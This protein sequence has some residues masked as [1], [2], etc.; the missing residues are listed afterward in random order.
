VRRTEI[1]PFFNLHR[2]T[3]KFITAISANDQM[4]RAATFLRTIFTSMARTISENIT[5]PFALDIGGVVAFAFHATKVLGHVVPNYE[6][7]PATNAS[8][9]D[10]SCGVGIFIT[11]TRTKW[12]S[13]IE[14]PFSKK[15]I[16]TIFADKVFL[17][18]VNLMGAF[19]RAINVLRAHM[20]GTSFEFLTTNRTSKNNSLPLSDW[21]KRELTFSGTEDMIRTKSRRITSYGRLADDTK[22]SDFHTAI[23]TCV[24]RQSNAVTI[25]YNLE[26]KNDH[27]YF[28]NGALV[29]NCLACLAMDGTEYGLE[30]E[31]DD[32]PAGRC[33]RQPI[34]K[35]LE[36]LSAQSGA[37]WFAEQSEE[38]QRGM[39]GDQRFEAWQQ[40][41]FEFGQLAQV[42]HSDEWGNSVQVAPLEAVI[43]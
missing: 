19:G 23:I 17:P 43:Q 29:H 7:F 26:I 2:N 27:T 39:M 25:V 18:L 4:Q 14:R 37:D 36:P 42:A 28:A 5:A 12:F 41:Q 24:Q 16:S 22:F 33:F 31:L 1:I 21:N 9:Y 11:G 38:V 35:G 6:F 30:E 20:G 40:G 13:S 3:P 10:E 34:I 32:H 15:T 8:L